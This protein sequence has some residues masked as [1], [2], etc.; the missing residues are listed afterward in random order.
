M[1]NPKSRWLLALG[2]AT[3][4]FGALDAAW[5]AGVAKN[6]YDSK[7]PHLMSD[8]IQA[9][10]AGIFYAGYLIGVVHLVVQPNNPE[11][12]SLQ[13]FRDG[14][15]LGALAYGTWGFTG[16]SVLKDFPLSVEISDCAWG[17]AL[18]GIASLVA[19]KAAGKAR[20]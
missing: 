15:I 4:T 20:D 12:T 16:A 18:T 2:G 8:T 6:I 14:A 5:I 1:K 7:I 13:R 3:L 10:P 19:A 9:A 11:R 17:A